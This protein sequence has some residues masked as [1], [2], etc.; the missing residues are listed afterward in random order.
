MKKI[1]L[2]AAMMLASAMSMSAYDADNLY[3]VGSGCAAGW[4]PND[5]LEMTK[6]ENNIFTWT[7]ELSASGEFKFLVAREW[8][9]SITCNFETED[10]GNE[11][12]TSGGLYDLYVRP[13]D[14]TGKD[15]KFQ[16]SVSGIYTINVDLNEMKMA[17]S[18]DEEIEEPLNLYIV[19]DA[20]SGGWDLNNAMNQK[21]TQQDNG[22]YSWDGELKNGNFRFVLGHDWWPSYS[23]DCPTDE[24]ADLDVTVGEYS[25]K[26]WEQ[27]PNPNVSFKIS[28]AGLYTIVLDID[29]LKMSI[30]ERAPELYI[31]GNALNGGSDLW[32][33]GWAQA[34][35]PTGNDNE[36]AWN[37]YLYKLG[38]ANDNPDQPRTA[39]FR[40]I[41]QANDWNPGYVAAFVDDEIS[42]DETYEILDSKGNADMKFTVKENGWYKLIINTAAL[43]VQVLQG[44]ENSGIDSITATKADI[45]I[46]GRVLTISDATADIYDT[47]G[48]IVAHAATEVTLPTAGIYVAVVNGTAYKVSVK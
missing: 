36:F 45:R 24:L 48:R 46:N 21:F 44:D 41:C 37:G 20:T 6:V 22:T 19:G 43:T 30:I 28:E 8:H 47:M 1:T 7:G 10:Q 39:Q 17:A 27:E 3:V 11:T 31:I 35:T 18:L 15:N 4:S 14:Q 29:N 33:L 34:C 16:V 40:F 13:N 42:I 2:A 5:A 38:Y 23:V 12:V 32:D 25:I 9:P 26:L